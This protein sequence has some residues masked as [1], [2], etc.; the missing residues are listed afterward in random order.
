M[1]TQDH[2]EGIIQERKRSWEY[3]LRHQQLLAQVRRQRPAWRRWTGG[4]LLRAGRW[5]TR[6]GER[7]S[8]MECQQKMP[9][10]G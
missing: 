2:W 3:E 7:M 4:G 8:G 5:L 9:V 10:A 6:W 1:W